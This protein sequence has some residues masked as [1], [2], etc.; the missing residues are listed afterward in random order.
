MWQAEC[1]I[2]QLQDTRLGTISLAVKTKEHEFTYNSGKTRVRERPGWDFQNSVT[3]I[4]A[5]VDAF[6]KMTLRQE[7]M[8]TAVAEMMRIANI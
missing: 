8:I 5:K 6:R 4:Y 7:I 2:P 3:L 1:R